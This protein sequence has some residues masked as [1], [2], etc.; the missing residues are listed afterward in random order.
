MTG[1]AFLDTNVVIYAL[2]RRVSSIPDRRTEI[3][4]EIL[5][6]GGVVSVQV[7]AEFTDAVLRKHGKSLQIVREMLEAVEAI[8]GPAVPLTAEI[9]K[10][11]LGISERFAFRIYDSLVLAAAANKGCTTLYTEDMQHG[12]IIDG[13]RIVNPFLNPAPGPSPVRE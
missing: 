12:Q 4:E 1:E 5:S 10:A 13:V 11:A 6:A 3:A 7:L 2:V 9:H 8:C